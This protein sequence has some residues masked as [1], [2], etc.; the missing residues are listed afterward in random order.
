MKIKNKKLKI[1][2]WHLERYYRFRILEEA[3]PKKYFES[4]K[5]AVITLVVT[6]IIFLLLFI[7]TSYKEMVLKIGIF[8]IFFCLY[9]LYKV[10]AEPCLIINEDGITFRSARFNW[11]RINKVKIN[12]SFGNNAVNFQIIS[13]K[14]IITT[15]KVENFPFADYDSLFL[16][17]RTFKRK[18]KNSKSWIGS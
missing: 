2:E 9:R 7:F 8:A 13:N 16:I 10:F 12:Y 4:G 6:F 3:A 11:T 15:E 1:K 14:N 17:L 18:H 5:I